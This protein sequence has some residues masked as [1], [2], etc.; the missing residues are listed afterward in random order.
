MA[1]YGFAASF[2]KTAPEIQKLVTKATA[3]GWEMDKFLD[4]L[5][6][7]SW[8]K[9]RSDAQKRYDIEIRENPGQVTEAVR[10]MSATI[11]RMMISM[12]FSAGSMSPNVI[13]NLARQHIRN[14]T[15]QEELRYIIGTRFQFGG[16]TGMIGRARAD[17]AK[18]N[19]EYGVSMS[20]G[21]MNNAIET[22]LQG[23][24]TVDD[25][26]ANAIT[27]AKNLYQGA[28]PQLDQGFT[29]RQ[30]LDP[31]IS[32]AAQELGVS[33]SAI[34]ITKG[35]WSAPA[36]YRGEK[37]ASATPQR[38]MTMDEWTKT[39]R[40]DNRY[41][42]DKSQNGQRAASVLAGQLMTAFGARG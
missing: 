16:N 14:G 24:M 35:L 9:A 40:T 26:R 34:D 21:G 4:S 18:L 6:T 15:S 2:L 17:L 27:A 33:E 25:Y 5:K 8:W 41:G 31:Y 13:A 19:A 20:K 28:A 32:A 42:F 12:G 36:Q 10:A 1:E 30:I 37:P 23:V 3:G 11:R 39:I 38:M 22:I 7:T 29:M